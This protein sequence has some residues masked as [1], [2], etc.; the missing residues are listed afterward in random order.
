MLVS[1]ILIHCRPCSKINALKNNISHYLSHRSF[2]N[3]FN[4][5]RLQLHLHGG[6]FYHP[7][8]TSQ[9]DEEKT[10]SSSSLLLLSTS[11]TTEM[12]QFPDLIYPLLQSISSSN[13]VIQYLQTHQQSIIH[14][15]SCIFCCCISYVPHMYYTRATL[16]G[17]SSDMLQ[18]SLI[19]IS[20]LIIIIIIT[21]LRMQCLQ[22]Y[23]GCQQHL[24]QLLPLI[25]CYG[26]Q[27]Y[28]SDYCTDHHQEMDDEQE[29]L[30][31]W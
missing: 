12:L 7:S 23:W 3:S 20:S 24:Q 17:L 10:A 22:K 26:K 13:D 15:Y 30:Y 28:Y 25:V 1:S 21:I 6:K 2:N 18:R 14:I 11:T 27:F 16:I 19:I 31:Y 8:S 4:L 9:D 5:F 29:I